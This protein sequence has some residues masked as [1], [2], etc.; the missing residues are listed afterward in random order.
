MIL[1]NITLI[2]NLQTRDKSLKPWEHS[3]NIFI[4]LH[5]DSSYC[6]TRRFA[7]VYLTSSFPSQFAQRESK[8]LVAVDLSTILHKFIF[9]YLKD[10][11]SLEYILDLY[12]PSLVVGKSHYQLRL[13][14]SSFFNWQFFFL[15]SQTHWQIIYSDIFCMWLIVQYF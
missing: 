13:R 12:L 10:W 7:L 15:R 6:W 8:I 2:Q 1:C 4:I 11:F 9:I 5:L 3:F 14:N